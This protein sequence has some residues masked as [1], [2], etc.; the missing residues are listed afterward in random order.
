MFLCGYIFHFF[1]FLKYVSN[2]TYSCIVFSFLPY[3]G[4]FSLLKFCC[5]F[6]EDIIL[7]FAF[8][9]YVLFVLTSKFDFACLLLTV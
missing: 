4:Q 9:H 5:D 8:S 1:H 6:F 3:N 2:F 7:Y